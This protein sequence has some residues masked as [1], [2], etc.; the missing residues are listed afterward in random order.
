MNLRASLRSRIGWASLCGLLVTVLGVTLDAQ[1]ATKKRRQPTKE[2]WGINWQRSL[3]SAI[4]NEKVE[5]A[6]TDKPI[7]HF[8]VLG[9]LSGLM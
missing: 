2:L 9:N 1:E 5:D 8:R 3:V 6:A 7:M 4:N